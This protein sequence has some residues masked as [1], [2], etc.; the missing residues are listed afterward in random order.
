MKE[1]LFDKP[2][3]QKNY[4]SVNFANLNLGEKKKHN[5]NNSIT[6]QIRTTIIKEFTGKILLEVSGFADS[7]KN[8]R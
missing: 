4:T 7:T 3:A 8:R 1:I 5:C 6:R 2:E